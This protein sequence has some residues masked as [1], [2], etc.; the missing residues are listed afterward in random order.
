MTIGRYLTGTFACLVVA[1]SLIRTTRFARRRLLPQWSGPPAWLAEAVLAIAVLVAVSEVLGSL[2]IFRRWAVVACMAVVAVSTYVI[3]RR[4]PDSSGASDTAGPPRRGSLPPGPH[5]EE[6]WFEHV[7]AVLAVAVVLAEWAPS[8]V[9]SYRLGMLAVDTLWYHGPVAANFV[10]TGHVLPLYN[11]GNDNTIEFY[12]FTSEL[13]HAVGMALTTTDV[14][15]PLVNL[16]WIA[17]TLLA[18]W[19]IGRSFGVAN[20]SIVAVA[21]VLATPQLVGDDAGQGYDDVVGIALLLAAVAIVISAGYFHSGSSWI[22]LRGGWVAA[23]AA[24]LAAGVKYTFV[25]PMVALTVIFG[26]LAPRRVRVRALVQWCLVAALGGGLW[27]VRNAVYAGNPLPN[28]HID[29]GFAKLPSPPTV[30]VWDPLH[31]ITEGSVWRTYFVPGLSQALGPAWW[32]LVSL[33]VIGLFGG[34]VVHARWWF[35]RHDRR[36]GAEPTPVPSTP[37]TSGTLTRPRPR[38]RQAGCTWPAP[39]PRWESRHSWPISSPRSRTSRSPSSTT[40]VS[41]CSGWRAGSSL[42]AWR[43]GGRFSCSCCSWFLNW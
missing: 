40:S 15:S 26:V 13:L 43:S 22:D 6:R 18:A 34:L 2:G 8:V 32:V 37:T 24:G 4:L 7:G 10:V 21:A 3:D 29:L 1:A 23:M 31:F 28:E 39:W 33:A 20:L 17:L 35:A 30:P 36:A 38:R 11:V 42:W 14:L 19:C 5:R 25:I 27:Y 12:P 41:C 16:G 9:Q